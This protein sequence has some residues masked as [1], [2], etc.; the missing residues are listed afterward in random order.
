MRNSPKTTVARR[1][2]KAVLVSAALALSLV[3]GGC[4]WFQFPGV[5][6][7]TIQQGN[8]ITQEM[9]DQLEPGMTKRQV[10]FVLGTPLVQDSFN[11]DRWDYLYMLRN[12]YG[13]DVH[14]R[15]TVFFENDQL[16]HFT[17]DWRPT[18]SE[19]ANEVAEADGDNRE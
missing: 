13:E 7:L 9:V 15:F 6:R 1:S 2:P 18:P 17:G 8:I 19:P 5:Y 4:S 16:T 11:Q 3:L 10:N 12:P 14:K